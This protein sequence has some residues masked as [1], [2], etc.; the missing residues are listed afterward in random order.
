MRSMQKGFAFSKDTKYHEEFYKQFP[1]Q[2]TLDQLVSF[3]SIK[4]DMESSAPMD[5]LLCGD[6][7]F[8]KTEVAFRAMFKAVYDANKCCIFVQPPFFLITISKCPYSF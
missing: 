6:V 8:G 5:R 4:K 1:Y 2:P 7:G 3:E